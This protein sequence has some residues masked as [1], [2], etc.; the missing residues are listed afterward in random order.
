MGCSL[1]EFM[2][3]SLLAL[4]EGTEVSLCAVAVEEVDLV[5]RPCHRNGHVLV[6]LAAEF[7]GDVPVLE[8]VDGGAVHALQVEALPGGQLRGGGIDQGGEVPSPVLEEHRSHLVPC[9]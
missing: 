9:L 5:A 7:L 1:E 8:Q 4:A 6:L 2:G 3:E